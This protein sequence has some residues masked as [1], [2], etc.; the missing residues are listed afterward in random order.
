MGQFHINNIRGYEG[1]NQLS[2]SNAC[3]I[4]LFKTLIWQLVPF[5]SSLNHDIL[6]E[7]TQNYC[8]SQTILWIFRGWNSTELQLYN[9]INVEEKLNQILT[10]SLN[11]SMSS[12]RNLFSIGFYDYYS[13]KN[14]QN[15]LY[16]YL[17]YLF[18]FPSIN[19][20]FS[21]KLKHT[22]SR[23]VFTI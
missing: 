21:P 20:E 16:Y 13:R 18:F 6:Q 22:N 15:I 19:V 3:L 14:S 10:S 23:R 7:F 1:V 12:L 5:H 17:N 9:F 2:R 4:W 11:F 8:K